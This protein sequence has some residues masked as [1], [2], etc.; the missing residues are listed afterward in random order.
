[1]GESLVL[2][3]RP[4]ATSYLCD[5]GQ[6]LGISALCLHFLLDKMAVIA[7]DLLSKDVGKN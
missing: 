2:L 7:L 4:P 3:V 5:P 1:M 6:V